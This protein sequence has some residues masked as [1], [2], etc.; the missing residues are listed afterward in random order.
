MIEVVDSAAALATLAAARAADRLRTAVAEHG[1]ATLA[2]SGGGTPVGTYRELSRAAL[3]WDRVHVYFCD[4][5][6]V[7]PDDP[8]SNFRMAREALCAPAG[9]PAVHVHRMEAER[10]DLERAA[11][12]YEAALP[13]ALDLLVLG[14][15]EDG[16][17]CSLFPGSP[18][19]RELGR[20]VGVVRD[21]P[22][23]PPVRITLTPAALEAARDGLVL[24][25]GAGKAGAVARALGPD[26]D[27][28]ATPAA[29]LRGRTWLLDR[30]AASALPR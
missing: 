5:R 21:S 11:A 30:A 7:P 1:T 9:I 15:G 20:R 14:V 17:T 2:L 23:P 26:A 10:A 4:E 16:H 27:P 18:L 6:G 13:E 28:A 19:V 12:D 3:P 8:R 29:L 24:V 25:A 22:K